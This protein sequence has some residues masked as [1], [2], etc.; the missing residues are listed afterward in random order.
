[1]DDH[2]AALVAEIEALDIARLYA[3]AEPVV[4]RCLGD[5]S[6]WAITAL[7]L[8]EALDGHLDSVEHVRRW[9]PLLADVVIGL[10]AHLEVAGSDGAMLVALRAGRWLGWWKAAT[11][12]DREAARALGVAEWPPPPCWPAD[13]AR[14]LLCGPPSTVDE[15][16]SGARMCIA[17]ILG[18]AVLPLPGQRHRRPWLWCWE[19][20]DAPV[21]WIEGDPVPM[22]VVV[23][24][25]YEPG[26]DLDW[27]GFSAEW[28]EGAPLVVTDRDRILDAWSG[29]L[30]RSGEL[31][32]R[33][34]PVP[35]V[36]RSPEVD[37][38][39]Y[40]RPQPRPHLALVTPIQGEPA[41]VKRRAPVSTQEAI[42]RSPSGS[43]IFL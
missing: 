18:E 37:D 41:R 31:W 3:K 12:R 40:V 11:D 24:A 33:G 42:D 10:I 8:A 7:L 15:F 16:V 26:V 34:R 1:M 38:D 5:P 21:E 43:G 32:R 30:R 22:P 4:R 20:R 27:Y 6:W 28:V 36:R 35:A 23:P 9:D 2:A 25:D 19:L 14:S 17:G 29:R 39:L 13:R